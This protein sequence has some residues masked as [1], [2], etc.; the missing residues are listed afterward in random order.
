MD[1]PGNPPDLNPIE[2]CWSFM[3]A[4]LKEDGLHD[5]LAAFADPGNQDDVGTGAAPGLL[6]E[7][8]QLYA[9]AYQGSHGIS[10]SKV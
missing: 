9:Q 4:K 10:S 1:W 3:K 7:D 5:H 2:N 6:P 8:G